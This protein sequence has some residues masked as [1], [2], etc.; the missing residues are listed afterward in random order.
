MEA[1]PPR[2][3]P[4]AGAVLTGGRSRRM[5]RDKALL[6]VDG[7]AMARRV[8]DALRRAG[9]DPVV[10]VGGDQ[11]ALAALGLDWRRDRYPGEGPLGGLL[12]AFDALPG[13]DVVAVVATDLPALT[14][15]VVGAVLV[16][17]DAHDVALARTDR[18][19]PLCG[20]WRA[21][22][23]PVLGAAFERGERSIHRAVAQL[24]VVEVPVERAALRNVNVP[25]DL[26][27]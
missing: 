9:A 2:G 21:R 14:A 20:V 26:D 24:D 15:E 25:A 16:E 27:Q 22:S 7:T 10:A 13:V 8:A 23:A 17:L 5:G 11:A 19:E 3:A 1:A 6:P 12:S 18:L 4:F